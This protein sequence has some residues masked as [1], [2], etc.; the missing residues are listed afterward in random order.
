MQKSEPTVR[1]A[2]LIWYW[3]AGFKLAMSSIDEII[4][5]HPAGT[6]M[7]HIRADLQVCKKR[8]AVMISDLMWSDRTCTMS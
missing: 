3:N 6:L 5:E 1:E 7:E 2:A 8:K 4:K